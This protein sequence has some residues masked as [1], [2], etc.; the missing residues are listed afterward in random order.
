MLDSDQIAPYFNT[1]LSIPYLPSALPNHFSS[2]S[3][4]K[5]TGL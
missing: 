5:G 3:N 4:Q 2:D 1:S